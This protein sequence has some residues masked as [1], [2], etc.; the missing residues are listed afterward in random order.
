VGLVA[1]ITQSNQRQ[2]LKDAIRKVLFCLKCH[3]S[4][5]ASARLEN[6]NFSRLQPLAAPIEAASKSVTVGTHWQAVM[7]AAA[8]AEAAAA[9]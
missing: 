5:T 9:H 4:S 1:F 6:S 7:A 8:A 2:L 3:R